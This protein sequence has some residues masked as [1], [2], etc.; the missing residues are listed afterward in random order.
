[1]N[2][3]EVPLGYAEI[4]ERHDSGGVMYCN[5]CDLSDMPGTFC[6]VCAGEL[7]EKISPCSKCGNEETIGAFCH[8]C[9]QDLSQDP[10]PSCGAE[11][12]TGQFC[13][14]CGTQ[15]ES[16]QP[17]E[18]SKASGFDLRASWD[19]PMGQNSAVKKESPESVRCKKCDSRIEKKRHANGVVFG[20]CPNCGT[21]ARWLADGNK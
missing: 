1:M 18:S 6:S 13:K 11:H 17:A 16:S 2:G 5:T 10:C 12:Q 8:V 9:G 15:L 20:E 14:L 4:E 3:A 7:V 21:R 19:E